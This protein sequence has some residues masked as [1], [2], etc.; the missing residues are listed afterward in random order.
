ALGDSAA[1][2]DQL[3]DAVIPLEQA[4]SLLRDG[5]VVAIIQLGEEKGLV[6][7]MTNGS[8]DAYDIVL[9][10]Q[11]AEEAVRALRAPIDGEFLI[12]VDLE[13]SYGMF[14]TLFGPVKNRVRDAEHLVIVPSGPLLSLP[15]NILTVEEYEDEIEIVDQAYFDYSKVKWLGAQTGI[16]TGVSISSFFLGRR[17][18]TGSRGS[19]PF[20]GF[21]DFKEFGSNTEVVDRILSQRELPESCGSDVQQLGVLGELAGTRDELVKVQSVLGVEDDDVVLG[22][23]FT[24]SYVK[25]AELDDYR[26]LHFATHGVLGISP[27]CLPEPGLITS[28]ADD[29]DSLLEA[30]EIVNLNLDADLVVMSAC[31]TGAGA[32]QAAESQIGFRGV[33]GSYAAGG[34]SLNGLAR[35]FFFA[36]AR[37][38]LSTHWS[39]D[40]IA[41]QTLMVSFYEQVAKDA[42]VSIADAM[43]KSQ[44]A[45][46]DGAELSHPF[47]WAP[48]AIIGDGARTLTFDQ[49]AEAAEEEGAEEGD[50]PAADAEQAPA[51][52]GDVAPAAD[53]EQAPDGAAPEAPAAD[54][55]QA[56][57]AED[58][59]SA[60]APA[61]EDAG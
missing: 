57:A 37:N 8:F 61:T 36:G 6:A 31:D 43:R 23:K 56:P 30:S 41:T 34:E 54:A 18:D 5:E 44:T 49:Q 33:G 28:I 27:D 60:T 2:Y 4:Q 1:S 25:S 46:V 19:K 14:D 13:E 12:K 59:E 35:G 10:N 21:G 38:V 16:T 15:F 3:I 9:N 32:G 40:D 24:D 58:G 55:E 48:F 7:V 39:V 29:G 42:D 22:D 26:V 11:S 53:A 20:L 47:F 52:D 50:V 45:L 17:V 51:G